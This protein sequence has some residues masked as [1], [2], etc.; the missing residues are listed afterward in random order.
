MNKV[1]P[2]AFYQFGQVMQPLLQIPPGAPV[3]DWLGVLAGA[4]G[5]VESTSTEPILGLRVCVGHSQRVVNAIKAI[6][7]LGPDGEVTPQQSS[8]LI[9][10]ILDFQAVF[11]AEMS[12]SD[13]Y[14]V[15]QR[16]IFSTHA[17][18]ENGERMF[19][20][21]VLAK[22]PELAINDVRQGTRCF[23]FEL[24]TAAG[25]HFLR[26]VEE[27]IH[28]HY[29]ILAK[30]APRPA[31]SAMGIYLDK[32]VELNAQPEIVAV[33]KQIK[34]LH[35]NPLSHPDAI[36]D[37]PGAQMV[38]G[39]MQSAIFAMMKIVPVPA[40]VVPPIPGLPI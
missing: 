14:I 19:Q 1:N 36:L 18:I 2:F 30:G 13:T 32:L 11:H 8:E 20:P 38:M 33:L 21:D 25:F 6:T 28:L 24:P 31:R 5:W 4:Q 27:V 37:M 16:S 34:D 17:L 9:G 29:D 35:R 10:A 15:P 3:K 12:D 23:A 26:A 40:P 22:M 39:L 7:Q